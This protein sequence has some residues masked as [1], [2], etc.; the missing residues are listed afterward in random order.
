M[1]YYLSEKTVGSLCSGIVLK[2]TSYPKM[3]YPEAP[4]ISGTSYVI[5]PQENVENPQMPS[6]GTK[7]ETTQRWVPEY[8][9]LLH[10]DVYETRGRIQDVQATGDD[11]SELLVIPWYTSEQVYRIATIG[12]GSC[13]FHAFLKAMYK[14]Y[15]DNPSALYRTNTVVALRHELANNLTKINP[16]TGKTLYEEIGNGSINTLYQ[17][18]IRNNALIG[19]TGIDYS[20]KGL[21]DRLNDSSEYVGDELYSYTA[22]T[23]KY[24]VFICIGAI[25]NVIHAESVEVN[26]SYPWIIIMGNTSHYEVLAIKRGDHLQ[27]YFFSDDPF[28]MAYNTQRLSR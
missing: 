1:I 10:V 18:M 12:D 8:L 7:I 20:L 27:T 9:P 26:D 3:I 24:N 19:Y 6:V 28:I 2:K 25:G 22:E 11:V 23:L 16:I 17:E 14:N 4:I 5:T 13:F 21:Q 15:Q